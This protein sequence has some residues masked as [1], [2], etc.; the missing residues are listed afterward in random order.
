FVVIRRSLRGRAIAVGR[1]FQA[2]LFGAVW[3]R[4]HGTPLSYSS[5]SA[6]ASLSRR[7]ST[8]GTSDTFTNARQPV[9]FKPLPYISGAIGPEQFPAPGRKSR[10]SMFCRSYVLLPRR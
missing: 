1:S 5:G 7:C 3:C 2:V 9:L 8:G 4:C 6:G 10:K